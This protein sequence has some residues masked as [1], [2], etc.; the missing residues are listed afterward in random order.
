MNN[1][2][3]LTSL[4]RSTLY[5]LA[6]VL[7]F[8]PDETMLKIQYR[9]RTGHTLH[10]DNPQRLSEKIQHYKIYYRNPIMKQCVD[11]YAVH[12]F[13]KSRLGTD[14]YLNEVYQVCRRP[15]EID[16]ASLPQQFVIKTTDGGSGDNV[17]I[18]KDKAKLDIPKV[19]A[20][21]RRWQKKKYPVISREWAYDLPE[22]S[23][24]IVEKLMVD[25]SNPDG[26]INDYKFMCFGG[27]VRRMYVDKGRFSNS[28]I[29][30]IY[31]ENGQWLKGVEYA[32][33]E[34]EERIP[35][36]DNVREMISVAEKLAAEF[37]FA[38]IDLYNINGRIIFGEITFYPASGYSWFNPD[39]EDAKWGSFFDTESYGEY[40]KR[41][42]QQ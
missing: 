14:R 22:G 30:T 40:D 36:P 11:K 41:K 23:R 35:M 8:L 2:K 13:V 6:S 32:Y 15:E 29:R 34:S 4:K 38:R 39:E 19:L 37:P 27:K 1:S 16:F 31:D 10:L 12:E 18:C 24:I 42:M 5:F 33:K 21:I 17:L 7:R 28:H 9:I 26:S 20:D 3:H 25:S